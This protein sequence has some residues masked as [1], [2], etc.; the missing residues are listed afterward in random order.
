MAAIPLRPDPEWLKT[1]KKGDRV[2]TAESGRHVYEGE[3]FRR[4]P[5]GRLVV[6]KTVDV[7]GYFCPCETFN[8]DG[9]A[10]GGPKMFRRYL[11]PAATPEAD[12]G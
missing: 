5:S 9:W 12:H 2:R 11:V 8:A 7:K 6:M 4:T 10:R 3:V 1:L